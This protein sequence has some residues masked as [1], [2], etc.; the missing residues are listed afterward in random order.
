VSGTVLAPSGTPVAGALVDIF[1]GD[2]PTDTTTDWTPDQLG[3]T[4]TDASGKW[5][6]TVPPYS[7]L[8]A[9][10]QQEA[11]N[12]G[13]TLNVEADAYGQAVTGGTTYMETNSAVEPVWVGTG[14]GGTPAPGIS[15]QPSR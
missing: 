11:A 8:P 15:P 10:A 5:S 7:S 4:T 13:G 14:T 3:T 9:S 12:N 2:A 1:T 6:F